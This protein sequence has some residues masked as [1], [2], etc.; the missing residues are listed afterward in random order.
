MKNLYLIILFL[1]SLTFN[2]QTFKLGVKAGVNIPFEGSIT[3]IKV[4]NVTNT[5]QNE[6]NNNGS[7]VAGFHIG[8]FSQI[9]FAGL[10]IQPEIYYTSFKNDYKSSL[11]NYT[12]DN[13]RIDIPVL[14][15]YK[16]LGIG[17]LLA[18]P[19]FSTS[20]NQKISLDSA[21]E[22]EKKNFSVGMQLGGGI[23]IK[24]IHADVRYELP[25]G[26]NGVSFKSGDY[27][28]ATDKRPSMLMFSLGYSF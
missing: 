21:K 6:I 27:N 16:V 28:F 4:S 7:G 25:F 19:V 24:K 26:S 12:V 3:E 13:G 10:L 1:F 15:G 8:L 5:A 22:V 18:G 14:V 20:L 9:G 2:A 11:G 23:S 17:R